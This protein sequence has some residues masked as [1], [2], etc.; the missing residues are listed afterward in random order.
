MATITFEGYMGAGPAWTDLAAN[1]LVFSG[2]LSDLTAAITV[3]QYQDGTHAGNGDPGTDQCGANHMNNVKFMGQTTSGSFALNGGATEG[4]NDT[5]LAANECT[6]RLHFNHTSSVAVSGARFYCFDGSVVTNEAVG[7]DVYAF[8]RGR[9]ANT[10]FVLNDDSGDIGG[11]NTNERLLLADS[12]SAQDHYW[13]IA[14]SASPESV[15]AKASFDFGLTL[16]YS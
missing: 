10:W 7:V 2:S 1:T 12:A 11:D 15:G 5:N 9:G 8:E 3:A 13:Y 14:L 4:L 6:L 16:T